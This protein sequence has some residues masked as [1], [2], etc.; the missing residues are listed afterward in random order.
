[1]KLRK[2]F[3][4]IA[5]ALVLPFLI[6]PMAEVDILAA[7][8]SDG[9]IKIT[10]A[11]ELDAVRDNPSSKYRLYAD[12][13]LAGYVSKNNTAEKGWYPIGYGKFFTGVFDGNGHTIQGLWSSSKWGISYKGLFSV[14]KGAV[15]KDLTIKLDERGITGGY[16]VGGLSGVAKDGT[17]ISGVVVT[18]GKIVVTGGGYAG[19]LI[20]ISR[21]PNDLIEQCTIIGVSTETSGNYSAGFIGVLEGQS[22]I[23][24]S[25]A[26]DTVSTG[27]SY[28]ANFVGAQKS[29]SLIENCEAVG[30][31]TARGSYGGG[32][33]GVIY[34]QSKINNSR[35]KG[36]VHIKLSYAGG[37]VGAI[38]GASTVTNSYAYSEVSAN[39]YGGGFVGTI[40]DSSTMD[41][42]CAY[43]NVTVNNYIAGGL[44]GEAVSST[45][46]N[47][48]ARGNVKGTTGVGGLVGYFSGLGSTKKKSITNSYSTGTVTG[49]T[50][51]DE[52]GAF[53]G[54]SGVEYKGTNFYNASTAGVSNAYGSAGKPVGDSAAF[55]KG[56]TT[57]QLMNKDTFT[58]WD[59]KN[60]WRIYDGD[61]Y[62]YLAFMGEDSIF[63][64][65]H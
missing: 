55:P 26:F 23:R 47:S 63:G 30:D 61:S 28:V 46:S 3:F 31:V 8:D 48:Y 22:I 2:R 52:L 36:C 49:S 25:A 43:G 29:Q 54:R 27:F 7:T 45:I 9:Y 14:L 15:V 53:N 42:V 38:Y 60:I 51:L 56:K 1:M 20:G 34:Q 11:A 58:G 18:G 40:Y 59:F 13:D 5:F 16:E 21:G 39:H 41:S 35:V 32:F 6:I 65:S 57:E 33:A 64:D 19:G 17:K 24:N 37:F 12:I 44:V 4:T 62:P 50:K 10:T